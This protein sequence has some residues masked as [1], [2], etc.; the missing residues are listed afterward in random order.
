MQKYENNFS[1]DLK[2]VTKPL[3]G[4]QDI[5]ELVDKVSESKIVMLGESTHGTK[6]FYQWR[7]LITQDLIANHNFNFLAVEGDWPPCQ[8]INSFISDKGIQ[9]PLEALSSFNRWPT[10][11]WAN[12]EMVELIEWLKLHNNDYKKEIGFYGLDVYSMFDSIDQVIRTLRK[13]NPSL[14]LKAEEYY[15]CLGS[16]GRDEMN[17]AR[18]L[19][20]APEGCKREVV[21]ALR[22][23]LEDKMLQ[24]AENR[25]DRLQ[26]VQNAKIVINAE[27]YYRSMA[28][29]EDL[30]W[31]VR[32]NHMVDTLE[33]LFQF[34]GPESKG[35][36]WAHNSH[37]GDYRAT[38]M[39]LRG[40]V[41]LGGLAREIF[42]RENVSLVGFG[43]YSGEVLAADAWNGIDQIF[44]LPE[45]KQGSLEDEFHR[46]STDFK[47]PNLLT[48]FNKDLHN[49][50]LNRSIDHRAVGVV[51]DPDADHRRN[52]VPTNLID[53]YD[54]FLFFDRTHSLTP[55]RNQFD[56][57]K[58]PETYPFG[59]RF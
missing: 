30:A 44:N 1:K 40:E 14:A 59:T 17:Y 19:F 22:E 46:I 7:S 23:I 35:I 9:T 26:I 49:S 37:I 56:L 38:D 47:S 42:G 8:S 58:Y 24:Q 27:N 6:E 31:N 55:I 36:I 3:K 16:F 10:W 51:Y 15:S 45:A 21:S 18:E 25:L 54:A 13:I 4:V 53:R 2:S 5:E 52:Y 12:T 41:N 34:Y 28:F 48:I 57:N 11:M 39:S 33:S 32:D 43:T 29:G 50:S 20:K